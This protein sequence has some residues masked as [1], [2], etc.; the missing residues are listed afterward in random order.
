MQNGS[1]TE[2]WRFLLDF[3]SNVH[4]VP[5]STIGGTKLNI[6]LGSGRE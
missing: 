5:I 6:S 1:F 2:S 3:K 4:Q